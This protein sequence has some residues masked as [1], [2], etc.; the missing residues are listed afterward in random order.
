MARKLPWANPSTTD[1]QAPA[2][3]PQKRVKTENATPK[4]EAKSKGIDSYLRSDDATPTRSPSPRKPKVKS[5]S[6]DQRLGEP[7]LSSSPPPPGPPE[8][9]GMIEGLDGDDVY[10][11]V[12]DEFY[13]TAQTFTAHLHHAEYKRLMKEAREKKRQQPAVPAVSIDATGEV[14]EKLKRRALEERQSTGVRSM[15]GD[16]LS[17][18]REGD[19]ELERE[20]EE[21]VNDPWA[22]TSLAPLMRDDSS[23]R[24]SL[25]GL[26]RISGATRAA[27]GF[28]PSRSR[29][30]V[31][32][33]V[34]EDESESKRKN[35][36]QAK[37][38]RSNNSL[39][40]AGRAMRKAG[41]SSCLVGPEAARSKASFMKE[42]ESPRSNGLPAPPR[43]ATGN[44]QIPEPKLV[45]RGDMV[46]R[47]KSKPAR[48]VPKKKYKSFIDSLDDFDEDMFEQT[49][50]Q[51][52]RM[53]ALPEKPRTK[54]EVKEKEKKDRSS[55]YDEIPI[56]LA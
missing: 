55:R 42:E 48:D 31:E 28:G 51:V 37:E 38:D 34:V 14:K 33:E 53:P 13:S 4:L 46:S 56:F 49:Q 52:S 11:M 16:L 23:S 50:A 22:G 17:S 24:L 8:I 2:S 21:K 27:Q 35:A 44:Y 5:Q 47:D 54:R 32:V 29:G 18:D 10:M 36:T 9:D 12:E 45:E 3:R 40:R 19:E 26:E 7:N 41:E 6:R 20:E 25:K 15:M 43:P 1:P 30:A 39:S